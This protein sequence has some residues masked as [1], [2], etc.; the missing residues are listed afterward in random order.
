MTF[1]SLGIQLL[2]FAIMWSLPVL[3]FEKKDGRLNV[4]WFLTALPFAL[5]P[6]FMLLVDFGVLAPLPLGEGPTAVLRALG[7]A[8]A[9]ASTGLVVWTWRTHQVRLALWHMEND[10][11]ASIVT[12]GPYAF[13][14]HPFYTSFLLGTLGAA[15]HAPHLGLVATFVYAA[16]VLD[17][18][19]AREERR[20]SQSAFGAE[21]VAYMGR[22][23]RFL[24]RPGGR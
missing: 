21:Y 1:I 23:G 10:A 11:P 16:V 24:P 12:T 13:V 3:F 19:A 9:V 17:R 15:C 20:L 2:N 22:T 8:L 14:R 4:S 6:T 18:T 7:V 5:G